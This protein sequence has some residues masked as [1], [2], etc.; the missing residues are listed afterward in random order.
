[1]L[2]LSCVVTI[3]AEPA[4]A[5]GQAL[6]RLYRLQF[7]PA[8]EIL[9]GYI[10][11]HP[12]D[13]VGYNMRAAGYVFAELDRMQILEGEFF[14]DDKRVIE[15]KGIKP[16]PAVRAN[17]YESLRKARELASAQL[18]RGANNEQALF[19]MGMAAGLQ[20]DY[21]ALVEKRQLASLSLTKESQ[22]WAVK[23]LAANPDF[24]DA[25]LTTGITEYL[26]G[27]VP[28]FVKWFIRFE[29]AEGS[30]SVAV[31]N[32]ELATKGRY[33]GPF[34]RVLLAIVHL[35]EKRPEMAEVYLAG[36]AREFPENPLYQKELKKLRAKIGIV[37]G[38][39]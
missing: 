8:Q 5:I 19:G 23:L 27:S 12:Q 2:F 7:A 14:A 10:A 29:K 17:V 20:S 38:R 36:L 37:P 33:F 3:D 22:S 11:A 28:F 39:E 24:Y 34:A 1:M 18:S 13:P 25:Y 35:R 6:D 15:K 9:S 31:R 30:K 26:L 21:M 32:L 4:D 16:D